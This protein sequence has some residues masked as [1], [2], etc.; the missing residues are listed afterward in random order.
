M[1]KLSIVAL[2]ASL[3]I[4]PAFAEVNSYTMPMEEMTQTTDLS[5]AFDN[6]ENLQ[7]TDMTLAEMQETEGAALPSM[8][9][10]YG[11]VYGVLAIYAR[12]RWAS[13]NGSQ[14]LHHRIL[15]HMNK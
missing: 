9:V 10:Y 8:A 4:V 14:I 6:V 2:S 5:F 11:V 13:G 7:V 3:V 1:K 15:H 12:A